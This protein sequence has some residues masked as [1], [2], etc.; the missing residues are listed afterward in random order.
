LFPGRADTLRAVME[1]VMRARPQYWAK[2]YPGDAAHQYLQRHYSYSDR[3]RYYWTDPLAVRAVYDLMGLFGD[4]IIPEPLIAQFL[5]GAYADVMAGKLAPA[6]PA[7]LRAA[8]TR[9]VTVYGAACR[10]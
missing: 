4:R 5:G 10:G 3:I 8:V 6:A 1:A 7:L 9:V 2:Y